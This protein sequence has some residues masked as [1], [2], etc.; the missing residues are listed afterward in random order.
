[1]VSFHLLC[2]YVSVELDPLVFWNIWAVMAKSSTLLATFLVVCYQWLSVQYCTIR[3]LYSARHL[4]TMEGYRRFWFLR[5]K[6]SLF[7]HCVFSFQSMV[8]LFIALKRTTPARF[9]KSIITLDLDISHVMKLSIYLLW[10]SYIEIQ[11]TVFINLADLFLTVLWSCRQY[12]CKRIL[13]LGNCVILLHFISLFALVT[14]FSYF[15]VSGFDFC[16]LYDGLKIGF[17]SNIN[18]VLLTRLVIASVL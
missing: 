1:M 3:P 8:K 5:L 11:S 10:T 6:F 2:Y 14:S 12:N 15:D 16:Y 9:I 17:E 18:R 13:W 4:W 7:C